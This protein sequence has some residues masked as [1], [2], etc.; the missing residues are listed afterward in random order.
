VDILVV[1]IEVGLPAEDILLPL[2]RSWVL[3]R[4]LVL[5]EAPSKEV[6]VRKITID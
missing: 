6:S 3:A 2:T 4:I 1:A 5:T